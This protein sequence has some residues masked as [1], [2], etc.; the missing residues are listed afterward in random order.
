ML[1]SAL[2][3]ISL[4]LI[5]CAGL[6]D[7]PEVMQCGFFQ[8]QEAPA[9]S[10]FFCVSTKDKNVWEERAIDDPKMK[11]A[12]ALSIDDYKK[13]QAYIADLK[14]KLV[15]ALGKVQGLGLVQ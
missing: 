5:S 2:L 10:S 9:Q 14:K 4:S 1:K 8:V 3:L 13:M 15:D 7:S 11:G 6:P 12:Q